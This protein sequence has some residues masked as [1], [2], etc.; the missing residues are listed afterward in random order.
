M[1]PLKT[2]L[3]EH[4]VGEGDTLQQFSVLITRIKQVR[5]G[6]NKHHGILY[7]MNNGRKGQGRDLGE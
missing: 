7:K 6:E 5:K 1:I 2:A 4:M 3:E